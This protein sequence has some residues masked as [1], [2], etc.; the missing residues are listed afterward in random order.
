M[1]QH[2]VYVAAALHRDVAQLRVLVLD[3]PVLNEDG[4]L[5]FPQTSWALARA[6]V[7]PR[8]IYIVERDPAGVEALRRST[9]GP[10][11]TFESPLASNA[12]RGF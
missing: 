12:L 5:G 11:H 2:V 8:H 9:A 4:T 7:D 1:Q 3:A 6:G 10:T